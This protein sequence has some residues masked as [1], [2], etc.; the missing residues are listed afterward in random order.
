MFAAFL[1]TLAM[2]V[3]T[4]VIVKSI[5]NKF[6]NWSSQQPADAFVRAKIPEL[7]RGNVP[8]E[9][10]AVLE[11]AGTRTLS[12]DEAKRIQP[13]IE[14]ALEQNSPLQVALNKLINPPMFHCI[15]AYNPRFAGRTQELD[16]IHRKFQEETPISSVQVLTGLSGMGTTQIALKYADEHKND[17][18]YVWYIN[19]KTEKSILDAY[20][21]FFAK[22]C[23]IYEVITPEQC[24]N[25]IN[26]WMMGLRETCLFIFDNADFFVSGQTVSSPEKVLQQY[27]PQKI[28]KKQHMLI[29]S[30]CPHWHH[31]TVTR[32]GTFSLEDAQTFLKE[33]WEIDSNASLT[34]LIEALGY[35]PIALDRAARY[36]KDHKKT[37]SSYLKQFKSDPIAYLKEYQEDKSV[38]DALNKY[39]KLL[40]EEKKA[41]SFQ[42][43]NLLSFFPSGGIPVSWFVDAKGRLPSPLQ[44]DFDKEAGRDKVIR[45][46]EEY[47]LIMWTGGDDPEISIHPLMR[48]IIAE[49]MKENGEYN[50]WV[51]RIL[52]IAE[53][54]A[55]DPECFPTPESRSDCIKRYQAIE[56]IVNECIVCAHDVRIADVYKILGNGAHEF[57]FDSDQALKWYGKAFEKYT[58]ALREEEN[59]SGEERNISKASIYQKMISVQHKMVL[60][61]DSVGNHRAALE[62]CKGALENCRMIWTDHEMKNKPHVADIYTSMASAKFKDGEFKGVLK[63][64]KKAYEIYEKELKIGIFDEP[65]KIA[66]VYNNAARWFHGRRKFETA[67]KLCK[68]ALNSY[69]K[70]HSMHK[71]NWGGAYFS[72]ADILD[73][74]GTVYGELGEE[75]K[76]KESHRKS[77][78]IRMNI[79]A[80]RNS[81]G[82]MTESKNKSSM[83]KLPG[84]PPET[85]IV[86]LV[87]FDSLP[88]E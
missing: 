32:I 59:A 6:T 42:L 77:A 17:Y 61:H 29:T 33:K 39:R 38:Y 58:K 27:L 75:D 60:A 87:E 80:T 26:G 41:S 81:T 79:P 30:C 88:S 23:N 86:H 47:S 68:E 74:V 11:L 46:L 36:I 28:Y 8:D 45:E 49:C 66:I 63:L 22:N 18:K 9:T 37:C 34:E 4:G 84:T 76:A 12:F 62:C 67:L 54:I 85:V 57:L 15:P 21:G 73:T 40:M 78:A 56:S 72:I 1:T 43:L 14:K 65:I 50:S 5:E 48:K 10:Q 25:A 55:S 69:E 31:A 13:D 19:A 52:Q 24:I 53:R 83:E 71:G 20:R 35:L 64:Y 2:N 70:A 16:A 7:F 44:K 82:E 3:L 51:N